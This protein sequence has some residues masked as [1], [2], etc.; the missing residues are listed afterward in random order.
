MFLNPGVG[1]TPERAMGDWRGLLEELCRARAPGPAPSFS[2]VHVLK[3]IEVIATAGRIGRASLAR[4]LGLGEG[5]VRTLLDRLSERGLT[6]TS[7]RGCELTELGLA[8]WEKIRSRLAGKAEVGEPFLSL[9][10]HNVALLVR[11]GAVK[12]RRGIE[13]RD[14]AVRAGATGAVTLVLREGRLA[15]PGITDDLSSE[16]PEAAEH[17]MEALGPGE[18]DA[19]VIC[20]ADDP[21]VAEYGALAAALTLI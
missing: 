21:L 17:I 11:G 1:I 14:E 5:A 15:I 20:G 6:R 12:V 19:I 8:L 10:K 3:A 4:A 7:R 9:G 18:G 2:E 16:R 13:Q